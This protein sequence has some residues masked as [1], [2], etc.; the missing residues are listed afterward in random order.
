M[1]WTPPRRGCSSAFPPSTPVAQHASVTA[2]R[3]SPTD[4]SLAARMGRL[5]CI[6]W[7]PGRLTHTSS[8]SLWPRLT[9]LRPGWSACASE[10]PVVVDVGVAATSIDAMPDGVSAVVGD[11]TGAYRWLLHMGESC[12]PVRSPFRAGNLSYVNFRRTESPVWTCPCS[13]LVPATNQPAPVLCV[14][15]ANPVRRV[16]EY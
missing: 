13:A 8:R 1:C 10:A 7:T 15:V 11:V 14:R 4:S 12:H 9:L 3:H 16:V 5:S 6:A 2:D